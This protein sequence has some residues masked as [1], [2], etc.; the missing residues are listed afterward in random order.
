MA[1]PTFSPGANALN[2]NQDRITEL[3]KV[4]DCLNGFRESGVIS[5][6]TGRQIQKLRLMLETELSE[7]LRGGDKK[8]A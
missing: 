1:H 6:Q 5:P 4:V 3:Q 2:K 7:L 8:I